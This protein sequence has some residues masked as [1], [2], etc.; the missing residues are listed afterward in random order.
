ME[1]CP[2]SAHT[3]ILSA[4]LWKFLSFPIDKITSTFNS[5]PLERLSHFTE[6][7]GSFFSSLWLQSWQGRFVIFVNTFFKILRM[8][9]TFFFQ[10]NSLGDNSSAC[11]C[12]PATLSKLASCTHRAGTC[13]QTIP[14]WHLPQIYICGWKTRLRQD[15]QNSDIY[16]TCATSA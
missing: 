12:S 6:P 15:K 4:A 16:K 11:S 2:Q 9:D 5:R 10:L 3:F 1:E 8:V 13:T 14:S 7:V